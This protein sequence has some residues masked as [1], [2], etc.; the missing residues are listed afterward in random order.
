LNKGIR[1]DVMYVK[2]LLLRGLEEIRVATRRLN[3]RKKPLSSKAPL[4]AKQYTCHLSL[5]PLFFT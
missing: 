3:N 1:A 2:P 5:I 4:I